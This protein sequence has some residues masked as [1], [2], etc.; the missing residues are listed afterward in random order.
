M[1]SAKESAKNLKGSLKESVTNIQR[2][3]TDVIAQVE[4]G[5]EYPEEDLE[6]VVKLINSHRNE[7]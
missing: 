4:A 2:E 7:V 1:P 6:E 5:I 3:L